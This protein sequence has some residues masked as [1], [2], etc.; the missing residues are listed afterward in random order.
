MHGVLSYVHLLVVY[1]ESIAYHPD[2]SFSLMFLCVGLLVILCDSQKLKIF[3]MNIGFEIWLS[4]PCLEIS[5]FYQQMA[6]ESKVNCICYLVVHTISFQRWFFFSSVVLPYQ[7][8]LSGFVMLFRLVFDHGF[9]AFG[10]LSWETW[11]APFELLNH[12]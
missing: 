8:T 12:G 3:D 4:V 9:C 2:S 11:R 7:H 6:P 1:P 5:T 10:T